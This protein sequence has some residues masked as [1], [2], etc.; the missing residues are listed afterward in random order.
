MKNKTRIYIATHRPKSVLHSKVFQP[1]QVGAT[2]N[3]IIIN[4]DYLKDNIGENI[5]HLNQTFNELTALYWM[6]YNDHD[7][8]ILG[9][10]HYRRFLN[11][12][13]RKLFFKKETTEIIQSITSKNKI[14][15]KL[16]NNKRVTNKISK[17]L[18][19][20]DI[21][22]AKPAFC[23]LNG[24]WVSIA[25]DYKHN[26]IETDWD[27]CM[28]V[29]TKKYPNYIPSISKYLENSNRFYIGNMFIANRKWV[30]QY[31][32]WLFDILFEVAKLISPKDDNYQNRVI[33]FLSERLFTLYIL[34]HQFKLKE[35][36]ILLI[37]E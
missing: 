27:I 22:V 19:H 1:I 9:L 33:G 31:S 11:I 8:E 6:Q 28:N 26:H 34:H 24:S 2:I 15:L 32:E 37:Q 18:T 36:P 21:I 13:Y 25:Q 30:H 7:A 14:I 20:F 23:S 5:S 12:L 16:S 3:P 17:I 10:A 29:I 4:Q 35:V